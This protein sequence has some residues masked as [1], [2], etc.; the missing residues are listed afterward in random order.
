MGLPNV[1]YSNLYGDLVDG[2]TAG[3]GITN[4]VSY[5]EAGRLLTMRFPLGGNLWQSYGYYPWHTTDPYSRSSSDSNGRLRLVYV[6]ANPYWGDRYG[7]HYSYDSHGNVTVFEEWI[8]NAVVTTASFTYDVQNR[9]TN[10]YGRSYGY[11]SAGRMTSYEGT[12]QSFHPYRPHAM[13]PNWSQYAVDLNGNFTARVQNGVAQ[14]LTWDHENRLSS[15][16]GAGVNESYL[17]DSNGQR[18]KKTSNGSITYYPNQYYE[19]YGGTNVDKYYYFNGQPIALRRNGWLVYMHQDQLGNLAL[20]TSGGSRVDDQGFYAYGRLRRGIIGVE[21]S[22]TGQQK[23]FSSGLIYFNARYYDPEIGT[24]ISPDTLVPDPTN[25]FA[26]NRYM[27]VAGNPMKYVDP[28]G[29]TGIAIHDSNDGPAE[30]WQK[31]MEL[32]DTDLDRLQGEI[33]GWLQDH[34]QEYRQIALVHQTLQSYAEAMGG[35][36]VLSTF[37][38]V[39]ANAFMGGELPALWENAS[40]Q[41]LMNEIMAPIAG[42]SMADTLLGYRAMGPGFTPCSFEAD[43]LVAT[44]TGQ[45]AIS[46]ITVGDFALAFNETTGTT[47]YYTVTAVLSHVDP[48]LVTLVINGERIVTTPEHPFYVMTSAPWLAAGEAVGQ[49]KAAGELVVGDHIRQANGLAGTVQAMQVV[50]QPQVMYNL[51]VADAHTFFVGDGQWLVHNQC[52]SSPLGRGSTGRSI[53]SDLREQLALE[54]VQADPT[55][56]R[57]LR[58]NMTDPRWPAQDGWV[59]MAQNHNGIEIHYTYNTITGAFDDLKFK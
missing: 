10:G 44:N 21:R 14:T 36:G 56:G 57:Q 28:S 12:A 41:Q 6:G 27:Y 26:Y 32:Y 35:A 33:L 23:D 39:Y 42:A 20:V 13:A 25:V 22:F 16:T 29:H 19:Q 11:D 4:G 53:P 51:T 34:Q 54:A 2:T 17:Y 49:W 52:N 58:V 45:T 37:E 43:T 24:F 3:G 1:L 15:L 40:A 47:G 31:W 48:V 55:A 38:S 5:D 30:S 8:N 9:L 59:K 46:D 7:S 18:V 50:Q